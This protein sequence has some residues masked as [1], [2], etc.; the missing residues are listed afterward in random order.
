MMKSGRI[1]VSA[2]LL[3]MSIS[4]TGCG[5]QPTSLDVVP[6]TETAP[7]V[8]MSPEHIITDSPQET[9]ESLGTNVQ[10]NMNETISRDESV[11]R[12]IAR[13]FT[14][15]YLKG[16]VEGIKPYLSDEAGN[17]DDISEKNVFDDLKLFIFKGNLND[18]DEKELM[19]VHYKFLVL[20]N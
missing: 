8:S 20:K 9:D 16:D 19:E 11:I 6:E 18:I 7:E 3:S 12:E 1:A 4:L 2:I 17:R 13:L 5:H 15:A 10:N 14:E